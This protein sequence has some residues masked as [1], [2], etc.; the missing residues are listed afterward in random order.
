[1][2]IMPTTDSSLSIT[3]TENCKLYTQIITIFFSTT[4]TTVLLYAC[5]TYYILLHYYKMG[6][7]INKLHHQSALI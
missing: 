7:K 6:L 3:I 1:M 4:S 2:L 5:T